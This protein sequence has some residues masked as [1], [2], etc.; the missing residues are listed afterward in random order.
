MKMVIFFIPDES[1]HRIMKMDSNSTQGIIVAGGDYGSGTN[2]LKYP[3]GIDL[4]ADG[5]L[6]ISDSENNRII[7]WAQGA[8]EGEV[9][10]GQNGRGNNLQQLHNNYGVVNYEEGICM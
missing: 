6:F 5:V 9:V 10:A 7:K 4:N 2:Q 1:N 3:R 8:D